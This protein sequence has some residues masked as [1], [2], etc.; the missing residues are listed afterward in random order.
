MFL[1]NL[2]EGPARSWSWSSSTAS[3]RPACRCPCWD[4]GRCSRATPR[5]CSSGTS[6]GPCR[7]SHAMWRSAEAS[8]TS[9]EDYKK[10]CLSIYSPVTKRKWTLQ[11]TAVKKSN[12]WS[13]H[14][15]RLE[16]EADIDRRYCNHPDR[17]VFITI[18]IMIN[19]VTKDNNITTIIFLQWFLTW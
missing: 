19:T 12:R 16:S 7:T 17:I 2:L 5:P 15:F 3:S 8:E 18:S 11:L 14:A 4:C 13:F 1:E 9:T 6:D 10:K